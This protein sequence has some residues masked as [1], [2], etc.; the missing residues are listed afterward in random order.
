MPD[1]HELHSPAVQAALDEA[2]EALSRV[3]RHHEVLDHGGEPCQD[4]RMNMVAW[5]AHRIGWVPEPGHGIFELRD[6]I[7]TYQKHHDEDHGG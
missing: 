3:I 7:E 5:V 6:R 2:V 1:N 4:E